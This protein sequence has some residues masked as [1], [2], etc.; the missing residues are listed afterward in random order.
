MR[1]SLQEDGRHAGDIGKDD[2]LKEG[3][4]HS[5]HHARDLQ[6]AATEK[7]ESRLQQ[8]GQ[9]EILCLQQKVVVQLLDRYKSANY[10]KC[11]AQL[12]A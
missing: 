3:Q 12:L 1:T 2:L 6:Q 7:A 4:Q 5:G 9:L 11:D 8:G 10:Y